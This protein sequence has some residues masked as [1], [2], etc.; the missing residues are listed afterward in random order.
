MGETI[1]LTISTKM[2]EIMIKPAT[3]KTNYE[4]RMTVNGYIQQAVVDTFKFLQTAGPKLD[5]RHTSS[6]YPRNS[7]EH[8]CSMGICSRAIAL[9]EEK[10]RVSRI[11]WKFPSNTC[12]S[13]G[14]RG[15]PLRQTVHSFPA[16][17]Y[18]MP[19]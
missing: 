10:R 1:S 6:A 11:I 17:L 13:T 16:T 4:P 19:T 5:G 3:G 12:I 2:T 7:L 15:R 14:T 9:Y 18:R 8:I